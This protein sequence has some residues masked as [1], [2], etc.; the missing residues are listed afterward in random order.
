[1]RSGSFPKLRLLTSVTPALIA[2]GIAFAPTASLAQTRESDGRV[3]YEAA[4]FGAFTPSNAQDMVERIPG[5][6]IEDGD[7]VR[8]FGGAAGNVVINGVRPSAKDE[9]LESQLSRIPASQVLRLEVTPGAVIGGEYRSRAEVLNVILSGAAAPMSGVA[10]AIFARPSTGDLGAGANLSMLRRSG[11]HSI[12]MALRYNREHFPDDG[13]DE[14]YSEPSHQLIE[15]RDKQN[16]YLAESA[17]AAAT[18][19][20][21]PSE[22]RSVG[23]NGRLSLNRNPLDH[24]SRVTNLSGPLRNDTID[25]A[26]E[27]RTLEIGADAATPLAG[28]SIKLVGLLRRGEFRTE[29]AALRYDLDYLLTGGF[30]Q[31]IDNSSGET[32][33]RLTWAH[34]D[35]AGWSFETGGEVA[36]NTLSSDV[37]LFNVTPSGRTEVD[38]PVSD[39][40][41]EEIRGEGFVSAGRQLRPNLDFDVGVT[42]ETSRLTV[43]GDAE[44]EHSLTFLKPR[45]SLEWRP[46]PEWRLR[47]SLERQV[48]QLDFNDF[49]SSA[50][51]ANNR[52]D[53][54]N[55]DLVPERNW[56]LSG[57]VERTF[58]TDGR[59]RFT[60][61]YDAVELVQDRVPVQ[62]GLDAP[63]NLGDG[64][65]ISA[66]TVIDLPLRS[67]GVP[68][69]RFNL[70]WLV[71]D[72]SVED[73][74]TLT[75][76]RFSQQTPWTVVANFRQ[77][78]AEHGLAWGVSYFADGG[79]RAY[80]RTETDEFNFEPH[81]IGLFVEH[82]PA[83]DLV[84]TLSANN[85]LDRQ[86]T[87]DRIFYSP[88]RSSPAPVASETRER[89][90]GT[91]IRLGIKRTFG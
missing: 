76:R 2:M 67:F 5:F 58:M 43:S 15:R 12:N 44:S 33:G 89:N 66:E 80:R 47:A 63:G 57:V 75:D 22:G 17:S 37:R 55:A 26:P 46:Q 62:L 84:I 48:G 60:V 8:G 41:V 19:R 87:R 72:S 6:T 25:Q 73:P 23:M 79:N 88:D 70:T 16:D 69:G 50:E 20:W 83:D 40:Q 54:G 45:T 4:W 53:A 18:W 42:V 91:T 65:R 30:A 74:Y 27:N 14:L 52:I 31:D 61:N 36:L 39:V 21:E 28:G 11:A 49:A 68:G 86:I 1:M 71:Q 81:N 59:L 7:N 64:R 24:R 85:V 3:I 77:D 56:R 38:L 9:S 82:K 35:I 51:L 29:E 13:F 32:V 34:P 90:Q 10:E 78:L